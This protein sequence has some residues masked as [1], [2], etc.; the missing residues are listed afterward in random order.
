MRFALVTLAPHHGHE[1]ACERVMRRDDPHAFDVVGMRLLS[2]LAGVRVATNAAAY[3]S[4]ATVAL[5]P[6]APRERPWSLRDRIDG[7]AIDGAPGSAT[8][9]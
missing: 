2:L 5:A 4:P 8:R 3:W 1:L 6:P 9:W 7:S